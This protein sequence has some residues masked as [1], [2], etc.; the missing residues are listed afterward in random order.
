MHTRAGAHVYVCAQRPKGALPEHVARIL[1]ARLEAPV[2]SAPL[3]AGVI[4]VGAGIGT[5][6]LTTEQQALLTTKLPLHPTLSL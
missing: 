2:I 1:M 4:Y 6:V 3:R 5:P